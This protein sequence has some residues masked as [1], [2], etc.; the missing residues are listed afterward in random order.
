MVSPSISSGCILSGPTLPEPIEVIA[1]VPMGVRKETVQPS[2]SI[3]HAL[4]I[5]ELDIQSKLGKPRSVPMYEG[6]FSAPR[7]KLLLYTEH[8]DT[9][10]YPAS[11]G[12]GAYPPGKHCEWSPTVTQIHGGMK[13]GDRAK[14]GRG[15]LRP[16]GRVGTKGLGIGR[17][18]NTAV[19]SAD[20]LSTWTAPPLQ[21]TYLHQE[22]HHGPVGVCRIA[23]RRRAS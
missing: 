10:D 15:P 7:M 3:Q 20:S 4:Q 22:N 8:K 16:M 12:T 14:P 2:Q 13:R 9:L 11:D 18:C 5:Q 19:K 1:T 21:T 23:G 6:I 17:Q